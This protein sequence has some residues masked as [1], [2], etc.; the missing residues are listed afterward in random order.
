ML[1]R[2]LK[3]GDMVVKERDSPRNRVN[4]ERPLMIDKQ[5]CSPM[6]KYRYEQIK[7]KEEAE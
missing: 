6:I 7:K 1:E 4:I 3:Q 2:L 5:V